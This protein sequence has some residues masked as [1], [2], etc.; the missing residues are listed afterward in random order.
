MWLEY[1]TD[2]CVLKC[3]SFA[4]DNFFVKYRLWTPNSHSASIWSILRESKRPSVSC[5]MMLTPSYCSS[6]LNVWSR[7]LAFLFSLRL[8]VSLLP[9]Q[10]KSPTSRKLSNCVASTRLIAGN[11][12]VRLSLSIY[13]Y[14]HVRDLVPSCKLSEVAEFG[15]PYCS[16]DLLIIALRQA[17]FSRISIIS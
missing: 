14:C 12:H 5:R 2:L 15:G 6:V 7:R 1:Y 13:Y 9:P 16:L 3:S 10:S 11:A 8:S 4:G 17:Q